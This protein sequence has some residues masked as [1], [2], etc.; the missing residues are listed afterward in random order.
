MILKAARVAAIPNAGAII[1]P[2]VPRGNPALQAIIENGT[3]GEAWDAGAYNLSPTEQQL[4][5]EQARIPDYMA[6][7]NQARASWVLDYENWESVRHYLSGPA[8]DERFTMTVWQDVDLAIPFHRTFYDADHV[9]LAGECEMEH[10]AGLYL[11][12]Y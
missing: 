2:S 11:E 12:T 1:E 3:A 4:L 8:T 10:H 6:S 5:I 9:R 7:E